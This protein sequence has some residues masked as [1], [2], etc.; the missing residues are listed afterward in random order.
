MDLIRGLWTAPKIGMYCERVKYFIY[1]F[2]VCIVGGCSEDESSGI[3]VTVCGNVVV[4]GQVDAL[5]I[6]VLNED[7]TEAW[8]GR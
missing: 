7:R 5:R 8:S 1:L 6:T 2:A 3:E 4:P